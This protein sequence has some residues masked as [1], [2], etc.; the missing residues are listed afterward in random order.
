M[1]E[2]RYSSGSGNCDLSKKGGGRG[3]RVEKKVSGQL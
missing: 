1:E 2:G 3:L